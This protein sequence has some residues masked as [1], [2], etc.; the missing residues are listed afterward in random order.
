MALLRTD[1]L[2]KRFGGLTAVDHLDLEVSEGEI[3]GLIGP[4][5]SGKTTVLN[6]ITGIYKDDG[7]KVLF[8]GKEIQGLMP[9][10]VCEMGIAR[11]FQNI[12][13]LGSQTVYDNVRLGLHIQTKADLFNIIFNTRKVKNENQRIKKEIEEALDFVGMLQYKDELIKNLPYGKQKV[14]EIARA[15]VARPKLLL[16]DE[17]A[18]GLNTAETENL[19][20]LVRS[21]SQRGISILLIEHEMA[22]VEG[23]TDKV[24]VINYGRKIAEGTFNEIKNDPGVIEAYLGT[25]GDE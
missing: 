4:N 22:F 16:L 8:D 5:G 24:Y 19:M 6:V 3:C 18:A 17:P 9:H 1:Q 21:I 23:L 10:T 7:G 2:V 15:I 20:E 14:L 13:I 12:R 11:T 25:R